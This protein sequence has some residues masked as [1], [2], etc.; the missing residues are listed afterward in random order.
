MNSLNG[1][2]NC[3]WKCKERK[4]LRQFLKWK[5][6]KAIC[7]S[8]GKFSTNYSFDGV[9]QRNIILKYPHFFPFEAKAKY[10]VWAATVKQKGWKE[11]HK[12]TLNLAPEYKCSPELINPL[13]TALCPIPIAWQWF[14]SFIKKKIFKRVWAQVVLQENVS[15]QV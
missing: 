7:Y 4:R 15:P 5:K 3:T 2:W 11:L 14:S 6:D 12:S 1:Q 13:G 8:E 10:H 9:G